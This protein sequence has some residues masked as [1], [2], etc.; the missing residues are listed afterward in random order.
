MEY[1]HKAKAEK[2]RT[3]VLSDQMEARRTK[4][5]VPYFSTPGDRTAASLSPFRPPGNV[6][7]KGLPRRG[8]RFWLW[9]IHLQRSKYSSYDPPLHVPVAF[10]RHVSH[11]PV[12][13]CTRAL[14]RLPNPRIPIRLYD[15]QARKDLSYD[16]LKT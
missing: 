5:K 3:K 10:V 9:K 12:N 15:F 1:I 7:P 4:N 16:T 13:L 14:Y 6:A 11:A 2:Q 8:K